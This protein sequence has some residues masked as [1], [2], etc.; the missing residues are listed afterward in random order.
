MPRSSLI[1]LS[2]SKILSG[3]CGALGGGIE[4]TGAT[5]GAP[6]AGAGAAGAGAA[7]AGAAGTTAA[8]TAGGTGTF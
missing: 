5:G 4:A 7:G 8:G 3:S 6:G 2:T 1:F